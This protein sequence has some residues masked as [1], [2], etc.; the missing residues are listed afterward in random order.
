M[1]PTAPDFQ[2]FITDARERK[3]NEALA[4]RIF[5]RDRRQ[6]APSKLKAG[7]TSGGS[8]ASRVGVVKKRA[9]DA[10]SRRSSMPSAGDVNG[11]W[12]HD[13]HD[14]VNARPSSLA[15]RIT[16]PGAAPSKKTA[17]AQQRKSKLS[18]ALDRAD[19]NQLN[20]VNNGS[21]ATA[22]TSRS[23]AGGMG[24]S[25]RGLAGPFAVMGQNFA[26]GTSAADIESAMTPIGGDM[27]SCSIVK[28][29]PFVLAE[30]VFSSRE[31]GERVIDTFND[32]TA[33]G[34]ILKIYA[35][36]GGYSS[37]SN[38][39]SPPANA[40]NGPRAT[41]AASSRDHV[42][43]GRMGF[44]NDLMDTDKGSLSSRASTRQPLYSDKLIA[45]NRRG[46]GRGGR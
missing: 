31:G 13:L 37:P 41:R 11:E 28:T 23:R 4:D 43:D 8:L 46:R 5:S 9:A 18:S 33:D 27:V 14:S 22:S 24:I 40:P 44:E 6:S 10:T 21:V 29:Q 36:P 25:I 12:T 32:K 39:A 26:P 34:R 1:A 7:A 15:S 30:M 17:P 16:R 3:K 38:T 35:K 45:G 20:V 2:K 19:I 42:V